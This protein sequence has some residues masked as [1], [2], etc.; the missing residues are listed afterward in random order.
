MAGVRRAVLGRPAPLP[1]RMLPE[2]IEKACVKMGDDGDKVRGTLERDFA[3]Y[4]KQAAGNGVRSDV[5]PGGGHA[6]A[7]SRADLTARRPRV[8][9]AE[10]ASGAGGARPIATR[11]HARR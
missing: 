1:K 9:H 3:D 8:P 11:R 2:E 5:G 7:A 6:A 4:A 10:A